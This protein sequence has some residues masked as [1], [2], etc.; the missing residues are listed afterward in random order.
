MVVGIAAV[1]A[2]S[3]VALSRGNHSSAQASA[4]LARASKTARH[5]STSSVAV[6][7]AGPA[8]FAPEPVVANANEATVVFYG[9]S[10]GWE[11]ESQLR[12][13]LLGAGVADVRTRTFGGTAICDWFD[14]MRKDAAELRPTVVVVEFS[15]NALTPCM[16]GPDGVSLGASRDAYFEKYAHDIAEVLAIFSGSSSRVVFVGAPLSRRV[17]E[18]H[19]A[20]ANHLNRMYEGF[21]LLTPNVTYVDAG[22]AVLREGHFTETLPCLPSEPCLGG[23]DADGVPVNVVRAPDGGHFCPG[24]PE[25][26]Q[27]VTQTCPVWSSG[28]YRFAHAIADGVLVNLAWSG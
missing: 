14:E 12:D 11:S 5:A 13:A 26:R 10:L 25:A 17:E 15:G 20:D 22:A 24:A 28:A 2:A 1:A 18:S 27:G 19:E 7:F 6:P 8:V 9:D 21:A 16:T 3:I 4:R 23:T